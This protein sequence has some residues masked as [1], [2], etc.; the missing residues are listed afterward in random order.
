M[1]ESSGEQECFFS[2]RINQ[3]R[4]AK[5]SS[6]KIVMRNSPRGIADN[7][8]CEKKRSHP[9]LHQIE[10]SVGS[11]FKHNNHGLLFGT[12]WSW[13][14]F[15][16]IVVTISFRY[17]WSFRKKTTI[18]SGR[19]LK[20]WNPDDL[21]EELSMRSNDSLKVTNLFSNKETLVLTCQV[22]DQASYFDILFI[23]SGIKR[24]F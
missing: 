7:N 11:K 16:M 22:T 10:L 12:W 18:K 17:P 19:S 9:L 5:E 8:H 20:G 24:D 21:L 23:L 15:M 4:E 14:G 1:N 3:R 6:D 13:C 2:R